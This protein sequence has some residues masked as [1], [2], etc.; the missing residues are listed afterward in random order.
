MKG[1]DI[2]ALVEAAPPSDAVPSDLFS[3]RLFEETAG[4]PLFLMEY[5]ALASDQPKDR[6][7]DWTLPISIQDLLRS[8][9]VAVSEIGNQLLTTAAVIGHSFDYTTLREASGRS[10]DE[11][12][13]AIEILTELRLIEEAG[14]TGETRDVVYDFYH[15]KLRTV[16]YNDTSQARRRLLH[17]R[18][19]QILARKNRSGA[20]QAAEIA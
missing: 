9:L 5:L 15:P 19:A 20:I 3:T 14:D 8:R 1:E 18:V 2:A 10:D 4:L 16:I 17:Q 7:L 6:D 13:A 12:V 11:T